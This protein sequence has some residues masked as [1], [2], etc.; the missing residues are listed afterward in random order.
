MRSHVGVVAAV[1]GDMVLLVS[2][3]HGHVV[4]EGWYPISRFIAFRTA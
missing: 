3:N 4:G 2:G 1:R